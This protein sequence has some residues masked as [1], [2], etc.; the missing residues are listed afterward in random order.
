[1]FLTEAAE[2]IS[3]PTHPVVQ[4]TVCCHT[5]T[6]VLNLVK[7]LAAAHFREDSEERIS[8]PYPTFFLEESLRV[9]LD[10]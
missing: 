7:V 5:T 8:F 1:M 6:K 10:S 9:F 4:A 2:R 3:S